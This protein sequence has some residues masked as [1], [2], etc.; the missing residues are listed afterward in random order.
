MKLLASLL[1][2]FLVAAAGEAVAGSMTLVGTGNSNGSCPFG[3]NGSDGCGVSPGIFTDTPWPSLAKQSGQTWLANHPQAWNLAGVDYGVGPN[4]SI[5]SLTDI[6]SWPAGQSQCTYYADAS[7]H[8]GGAFPAS[9][10]LFCTGSSQADFT[11]TGY[12]FGPTAY[13]GTPNG[14]HDCVNLIF[15]PTNGTTYV[16]TVTIQGNAWYN[17]ATCAPL[18]SGVNYGMISA[19]GG[20]KIL[21]KIYNNYFDGRNSDPCCNILTQGGIG[22]ATNS[23]KT[24]IEMK[25]NYFVHMP[26]VVSLFGWASGNENSFPCSNGTSYTL[27]GYTAD[28][29]FNYF[30]DFGYSYGGGHWEITTVG[31]TGVM[32][33]IKNNYNTVVWEN[34]SANEGTSTFFFMSTNAGLLEYAQVDHNT[35]VTNLVGGRQYPDIYEFANLHS[36][37]FT[38]PTHLVYDSTGASCAGNNNP[39]SCSGF[40]RGNAILGGGATGNPVTG[41]QDN[42]SGSEWNAGCNSLASPLC[43]VNGVYPHV[44]DNIA[45][46]NWTNAQVSNKIVS[47]AVAEA[48]HGNAINQTVT[49]NAA[50]S[51]GSAVITLSTTCPILSGGTDIWD[52][53]KSNTYVGAVLTCSGVTMTLFANALVA[54]ANG[55]AL[56]ARG[57]GYGQLAYTNNYV[58]GG[59]SNS[60]ALNTGLTVASSGGPFTGTTITMGNCTTDWALAEIYDVTQAQAFVGHSTGCSGGIGGTLTLTSAAAISVANSDVL[61]IHN[62]ENWFSANPA[63]TGGAAGYNGGFGGGCRSALTVTGNVDL[64]TGTAVNRALATTGGC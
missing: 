38:T 14:S 41:T 10:A 61:R 55:D 49:A 46:L 18:V 17:G 47:R 8:V 50:G 34:T 21:L 30:R 48:D 15:K 11:I 39:W 63:T 35:I 43:P 58:D 27:A 54:V 20:T 56:L 28:I 40:V 60:A 16:N 24:N 6:A 57:Y 32:C 52:T 33:S 22:V 19:N 12:N 62:I 7:T 45:Q 23:N 3:G 13:Q 36:T 29:S 44:A 4:Q 53:T 9:P 64:R 2:F 25:Y 42:T 26:S 31:N 51:T 37:A 59:G 1:L 5:A